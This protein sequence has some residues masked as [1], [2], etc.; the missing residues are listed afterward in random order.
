MKRITYDVETNGFLD[1]STIDYCASPYKLKDNFKIHS[2]VVEEQ[3]SGKVW[4]FYDGEK[5]ILDGRRH[6][7]TIEDQTYTLEAYQPVLYE[8]KQLSE[9][10]PWIEEEDIVEVIGHNIINFDMLVLKLGLD[11]DYKVVPDSWCGKSLS[12]VDTMILSKCLNADRFGGHSLEALAERANGAYKKIS[13][14]KHLPEEIRF[15]H[16]AADMLYYNIFDVKAN[17]SVYRYLMW[18]KGDW[19]W[20]SAI[21]LEH[22][23]AYIVTMSS[24]RG[25]WFNYDHAME[26]I[27][28][29]DQLLEERRAKVEPHLPMKPIGKGAGKKFT[30]PKLQFLKSGQVRQQFVDWVE[31]HQGRVFK[32]EDQWKA[33]IFGKTYDLP[34]PQES[35]IKEVPTTMKDS[36]FIKGWLISQGCSFTNW[37]ERDLTVDQ[38]KKKISKEKFVEVVRRYVESTVGTP[39]E[40]ERCEHFKVL[41]QDLENKLLAHDISKPLKALTNPTFVVGSEREI[42]PGLVAF[43]DKFPYA[44][45]IVEFLT[46]THRRNSI[47][48]GNID[49]DDYEDGEE[50]EKGFLS[51]IRAD[52]RIPT[53]ADTCGAGTG[54]FLHKGVANISRNTSLYGAKMREMFGVT[55]NFYQIG[56][57][58]NSQEARNEACLVYNYPGGI[59]YGE[60]LTAEKPNDCH[61]LLAKKISEILGK[62]FPRS[63]AKNV[64]YGCTYNAQ[65]PRVAKT[66]GCDVKTGEQIFNGFWEYAFPLKLAKE[67]LIKYWQTDGQKK[68]IKGI[69]G[70]KIPIRAKG[71]VV[72]SWCQSTGAICTKRA[73]VMLYEKLEQA[74]LVVDF[75][76]DDWKNKSFC[77]T[78]IIYHDESQLEATKD[79]VKFKVFKT[80]EEA[81]EYKKD[82]ES[83]HNKILSDIGHINDKYYIAYSHIGEM[84]IEVVRK[85]GEY[86]NLPI[87]LTAGYTVGKNWKQCH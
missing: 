83:K 33:N 25:F 14:R 1:N 81:I 84:C 64:K 36:T 49:P 72:N 8:H 47:L 68:F 26:C 77:Q 24:H 66:V 20:K 12:I 51:L 69:D 71:N 31:G 59:E 19:D 21:D 55:D 42:C 45:D 10:K 40:A 56:F 60:S 65:P 74:G 87:P 37:K 61:T 63:T 32:H 18:E 50:A 58:F 30:P 17:T 43:Q 27:K 44:K 80:E 7:T 15:K 29:L 3:E 38:K 54:R 76:K 28:E 48:G 75:F 41:P 57:D 5:I 4:A 78:L 16:F 67:D 6:E 82:F 70:R 9:F 23:V 2:I 62:E 34:I 85:S 86:Y 11:I 73:N 35:L 39:F 52:S 79:L 13:F 46:Y 22:K 53:R